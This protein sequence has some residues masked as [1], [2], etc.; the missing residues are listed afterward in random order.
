[1]IAALSGCGSGNAGTDNNSDSTSTDSL[2]DPSYNPRT[3]TD[4]GAK[5]MNLDST[6]VRDSSQN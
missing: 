5:Q 6:Q 3:E 4:S 2:V 1:M